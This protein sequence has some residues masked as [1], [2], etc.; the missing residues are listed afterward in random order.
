[1]EL[2]SA[3]LFLSLV[4]GAVGTGFFIFGWKQK[5]WP[6]LLGGAILSAYPYFVSNLWVMAGIAVGVILGVVAAVRSG[7]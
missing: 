3:G 2:S 7:L 4:I 5:R 6:Q 1:M